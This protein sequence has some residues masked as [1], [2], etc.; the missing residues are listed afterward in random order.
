[1]TSNA[2][3]TKSS[4][5][6]ALMLSVFFFVLLFW[7]P[8]EAL[9]GVREGLTLCGNVLIPALFPFLALTAFLGRTRA[10]VLLCKPF[11]WLFSRI[12]RIPKSAVFALIMGF[13]GG[14]PAGAAAIQTLYR[15]GELSQKTAFRMVLFCTNAGP[16]FV[17]SAI[18]GAMLQNKTAGLYL[19]ISS[20]LSSLI[21]GV[22]LGLFSEK[23]PILI[24]NGPT[25]IQRE[26]LADS[27]VISVADSCEIMLKICAFTLLFSAFLTLIRP[28]AGTR[29]SDILALFIEV[30]R[31]SLAASNLPNSL[32]WLGFAISFGG[33]CV[34][35]QVFSIGKAFIL[36]PLVF[37]LIRLGGGL[38]S[39]LTVS[40]LFRFF[41]LSSPVFMSVSKPVPALSTNIFAS[42]TLL[43]M[44]V[45]VLVLFNKPLE[46][47]PHGVQGGQ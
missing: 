7:Y 33:L 39:M 19:W 36:R 16:A 5:R 35:V 23:E 9:A 10:G 17:I 37:V 1:M 29:G 15:R 46:K 28:F 47:N 6:A 42:L 14:Y 38:L 45:F 26:S 2:K 34:H 31:G 12:F 24:K 32:L 20:S 11:A 40:L 41:P 25:A 44:C 3:K 30:S 13:T 4:E 27:F 22:I 21:I 8:K 43:S 18:G